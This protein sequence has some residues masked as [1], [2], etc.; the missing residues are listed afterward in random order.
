MNHRI[1]LGIY[2][3]AAYTVL[4][5]GSTAYAK[6]Q[7]SAA[8]AGTSTV[9]EERYAGQYHHVDV[10][11]VAEDYI[12]LNGERIGVLQ[13]G[14]QLS[15]P[16]ADH[17]RSYV[18]T[19]DMQGISGGYVDYM[20]Y[21]KPTAGSNPPTADND[22]RFIDKET[23]AETALL[24]FDARYYNNSQAR[25]NSTDPL[26]FNLAELP[27]TL[28]DPQQLNSYA[29]GRNNPI[30]L[31][32]PTGERTQLITRSVERFDEHVG[33]AFILITNTTDDAKQLIDVPGVTDK[34]RITLGGYNENGF[35]FG[36]LVKRVNDPYDYS[37]SKE[38]YLSA[39]DITASNQLQMENRILQ[40][41]ISTPNV[42]GAYSG[43]GQPTALFK[44]ANS[45]NTA[46]SYL[47]QGGVPK[48]EVQKIFYE[49]EDR[50]IYAPGL[51]TER[52]TNQPASLVSRVRS[53]G[54][55]FTQL[56]SEFRSM[57]R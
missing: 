14:T 29:Y 19:T 27:R 56:L 49:L 22:H 45:N 41:Y 23:D 48:Q 4:A 28:I 46:T 18:M 7:K 42:I 34:T 2:A 21:G 31:F 47:V 6:V 17:E 50:H 12:Y 10:G 26:L 30:S 5:T 44:N 15:F 8:A 43:V 55:K 9:H 53:V 57:F 33:H 38:Q 32:D 36:D 11:N 40:S 24:Y 25:F 37:L 3:F 51:G 1:Q 54:S 20:P 35:L 39:A 13:N 52:P 16:L